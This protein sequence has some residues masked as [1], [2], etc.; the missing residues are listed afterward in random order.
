RVRLAA[1]ED[2]ALVSGSSVCKDSRRFLITHRLDLVGSTHLIN[3]LLSSCRVSYQNLTPAGAR[4]LPLIAFI[5]GHCVVQSVQ[6]LL[7]P[8][9]STRSRHREPRTSPAL[10]G[11]NSDA[12]W[13]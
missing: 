11:R 12:D 6:I 2:A 8:T 4:S 9:K 10:R 13:S 7:Q 5:D 3:L 1:L